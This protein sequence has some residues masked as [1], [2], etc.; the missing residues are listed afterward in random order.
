[1]RASSQIETA[2]WKRLS[3]GL[4]PTLCFRQSVR[5]TDQ[6]DTIQPERLWTRPFRAFV[7]TFF[8]ARF[9]TTRR[10]SV[11]LRACVARRGSSAGAFL[12]RHPAAPLAE[13]DLCRVHS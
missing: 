4:C 10:P 7:K 1:M 3:A 9:F 13:R 6:L 5:F 2:S 8:T 12:S 11:Q